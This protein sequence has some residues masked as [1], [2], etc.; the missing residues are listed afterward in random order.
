MQIAI[1]WSPFGLK[2]NRKF[3]YSGLVFKMNTVQSLLNPG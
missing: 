3:T 1:L 2:S